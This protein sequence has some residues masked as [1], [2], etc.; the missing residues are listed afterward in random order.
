MR[1]KYL[2]NKLN[3]VASK[4]KE[5][6]PD[7]TDLAINKRYIP[8]FIFFLLFLAEEIPNVQLLP[9]MFPIQLRE[10]FFQD[11]GVLRVSTEPEGPCRVF[12]EPKG[13][14]KA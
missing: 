4:K 3:R 14:C 12:A 5:P 1:K 7:L 9:G 13:L 2:K 11:P 6:A 8:L 10:I